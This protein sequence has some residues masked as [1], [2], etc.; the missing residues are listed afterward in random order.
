[1]ATMEIVQMP[2]HRLELTGEEFLTLMEALEDAS[3]DAGT[4]K[5]KEAA[6]RLHNDLEAQQHELAGER[7]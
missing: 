2:T 7:L 4:S 5:K 3:Y 1:M 6:K